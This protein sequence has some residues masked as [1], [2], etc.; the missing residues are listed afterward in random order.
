MYNAITNYTSDS[1][2]GLKYI[3]VSFFHL[4]HAI[5]DL[6]LSFSNLKK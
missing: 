1:H 5:D 4:N 3:Y 6:H 2:A